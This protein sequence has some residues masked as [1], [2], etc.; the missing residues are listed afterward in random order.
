M[1]SVKI[2]KNVGAVVIKVVRGLTPKN[3]YQVQQVASNIGVGGFI[4]RLAKQGE[5]S[6]YVLVCGR[7]SFAKMIS[8]RR[9]TNYA[10]K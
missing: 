10:P 9:L 2:T 5:E 1:C 3:L 6:R 4:G 7:F 8:E